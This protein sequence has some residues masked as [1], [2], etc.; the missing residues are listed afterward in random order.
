MMVCKPVFLR[1]TASN[2]HVYCHPVSIHFS[3]D[4]EMPDCLSTPP[5]NWCPWNSYFPTL[6]T[7]EVNRTR[8]ANNSKQLLSQPKMRYGIKSQ[9]KPQS[10]PTHES[11]C[12]CLN[13]RLHA[14]EKD[15][16]RG[17]SEGFFV[18]L[19]S[20]F[21]FFFCLFRQNL[22]IWRFP[23]YGSNRSYSCQL[24]PQPQQCR[25]QAVSVTYPTAH[26]NTRYLIHW[27]K[28]GIEPATSWILVRFVNRWAMTGT[29][30][31]FFGIGMF[32]GSI[33]AHPH[34]GNLPRC[35]SHITLSGHFTAAR[36]TSCSFV[37][38]Q[39]NA[40]G[41]A[42]QVYHSYNSLQWGRTHPMRTQ[43]ASQSKDVK[44]DLEDLGFG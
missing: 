40:C 25:I 38:G 19:F 23:G 17:S 13:T 20:F 29:P 30:Q 36:V 41:G 35:F 24:T 21:F 2:F 12:G 33:L 27:S 4:I 6:R 34:Q 11:V 8:L 15:W 44:K 18:C 7:Q 3:N 26:S 32:K 37:N 5:L 22:G 16:V 10:L 28:S 42:R 1:D 43:E 31:C 9:V 39:G 14:R